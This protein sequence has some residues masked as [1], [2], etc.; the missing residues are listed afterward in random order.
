M[1]IKEILKTALKEADK[2]KGSIKRIL[3]LL[4]YILLAWVVITDT[5]PENA[6]AMAGILSSLITALVV[7]T[8]YQNVK[9]SKEK[10]EDK[11]LK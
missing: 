7:T 11:E 4:I 6:I 8:A 5:T 3:A 1:T 10:A 2:L 9:N